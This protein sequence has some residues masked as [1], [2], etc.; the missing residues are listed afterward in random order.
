MQAA[1]RARAFGLTSMRN[2]QRTQVRA[3]TLNH[4]PAE[5]HVVLITGPP[6]GGKGTISKRLKKEFD[7]I[8][9]SSGDLLRSHMEK[10]TPLGLKAESFVTNGDLV[11]DDLMVGLILHELEIL[12][13][14]GRVLLDG[15]PRTLPQAKALESEFSIDY[16]LNLEVP[17]DEI[18]ERISDRWIHQPSGRMYSYA[19]NPPKEQGKD[20][21]TGEP[22]TRRADDEP[23]KV[24]HRLD[25]YMDLT[26]PLLNHYK[27]K[28]SLYSFSGENHP[29]LVRQN[30]RSDA[31]YTDLKA[32]VQSKLNL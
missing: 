7:F 19:F 28:D 17:H 27:E 22:L 13:E 24:R 31:I 5:H 25:M 20:D 32:L 10:K 15:F 14:S 12:E 11:P 8:H 2:L 23:D 1:L 29:E 3:F 30:R 18:I 4:N 26:F 21:E 16:V 6:G 9:L